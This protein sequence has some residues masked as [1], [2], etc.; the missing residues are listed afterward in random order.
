MRLWAGADCVTLHT[1]RKHAGDAGDQIDLGVIPQPAR[2][3]SACSQQC[4]SVR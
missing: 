2:N 3:C 1:L 4:A